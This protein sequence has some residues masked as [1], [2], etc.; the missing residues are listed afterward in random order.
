VTIEN[1]V[2]IFGKLLLFLRLYS[3]NIPRLIL[4][5]WCTSASRSFE[6][7]SRLNKM[8]CVSNVRKM[9]NRLLIRF[10]NLNSRL[11]RNYNA[12]SQVAFLPIQIF[13]T[14]RGTKFVLLSDV[15]TSAITNDIISILYYPTYN[16]IPSWN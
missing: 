11:K 3:Q 4:Y 16:W 8:W 7:L 14:W 2:L 10:C 15:N 12:R 5:K 9:Y 6:T 13:S 1:Y